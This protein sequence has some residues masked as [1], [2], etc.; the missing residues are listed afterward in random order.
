MSESIRHWIGTLLLVPMV[1]SAMYSANTFGLRDR[2]PPPATLLQSGSPSGAGPQRQGAAVESLPAETQRSHPWWQQVGSYTGDGAT[3]TEHF[4]VDRRAIQWKVS[5]ECHSGSFAAAA[6]LP[7]GGKLPRDLVP[8]AACPR[9]GEGFSVKTGRFAL[10]IQAS[11]PWTLKIE[12]QVDVPLVEPPLPEMSDRE[13]QVV[14][15]GSVYNIDRVG[16]GTVKVY[17][18]AGGAMAIRLEDF[19]VSQNSDLELRL[20]ELPEPKSTPQITAAPAR[21]LE[22]LKATTGSMNYL[23]PKDVDIGRYRSLIIWCEL[24][25]NAY[26]AASLV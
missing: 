5:W 20:S 1:A 18:L 14:R 21:N 11:G 9:E 13:A 12:Q 19:F 25:H 24:T 2:F 8:E 26:A 16:R 22:F 7:S 10:A 17:K 23:I 6:L 3:V 4:S 15:T